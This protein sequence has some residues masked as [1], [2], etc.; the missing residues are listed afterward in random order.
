[1]PI[2]VALEYTKMCHFIPKLLEGVHVPDFPKI[3]FLLILLFIC[4]YFMLQT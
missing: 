2:N 3:K 4:M 1:M